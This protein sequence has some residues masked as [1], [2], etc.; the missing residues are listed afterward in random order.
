MIL[1][2]HQVMKIWEYEIPLKMELEKVGATRVRI[3]NRSVSEDLFHC[4]L[5]V[6]D[7]LVAR[8]LQTLPPFSARASG[9]KSESLNE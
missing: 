7:D 6:L 3:I 5:K 8:Q 4:H 2:V 1:L 9:V